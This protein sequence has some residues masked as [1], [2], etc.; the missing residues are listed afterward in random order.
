MQEQKFGIEFDEY[1]LDEK[2]PRYKELA[3]DFIQRNFFYAVKALNALVLT[4]QDIKF[5]GHEKHEEIG[6]EYREALL[7]GRLPVPD[8]AT[9]FY[10]NRLAEKLRYMTTKFSEDSENIDKFKNSYFYRY[11]LVPLYAGYVYNKDEAWY[12]YRFKDDG[13]PELKR[14]N[15]FAAALYSKYR[16]DDNR[17]RPVGINFA[18]LIDTFVQIDDKDNFHL[19]N[20]MPDDDTLGKIDIAIQKQLTEWKTNKWFAASFEN[21]RAT[22]LTKKY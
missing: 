22:S 13:N 12:N 11:V 16:L 20:G 21:P 6:G 1:Y 3:F 19:V 14:F 2:T 9:N 17:E 5:G 18:K 4:T 15:V 8:R 7:S 10:S